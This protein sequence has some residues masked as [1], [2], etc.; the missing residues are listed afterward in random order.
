MTIHPFHRFPV[1][2]PTI[3]R[4]YRNCVLKPPQKP[5]RPVLYI[6]TESQH[7]SSTRISPT[8]PHLP[9]VDLSAR[10]AQS[11]IPIA[12]LILTPTTSLFPPLIPFSAH[13]TLTPSF[14]HSLSPS[15]TNQENP[16]APSP[17]S[18]WSVSLY[19]IPTPKF[20][21]PLPHAFYFQYP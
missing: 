11:Q 13:T 7:I 14:I 21:F 10:S 18:S 4:R 16:P 20:H 2:S 17:P 3:T 15:T 6:I 9:T 5:A 8:F 1:V 12:H 19:Q